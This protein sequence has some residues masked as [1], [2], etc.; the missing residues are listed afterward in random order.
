MTFTEYLTAH[1]EG[2]TM[3]LNH[4]SVVSTLTTTEKWVSSI[5]EKLP[6]LTGTEKQIVWAEKLRSEK[7]VSCVE[8]FINACA[9]TNY[10]KYFE[11]D[12]HIKMNDDSFKKGWI[13]LHKIFQ[14][15]EAKYFIDNREESF[16]NLPEC[17]DFKKIIYSYR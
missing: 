3:I 10:K 5:N 11:K 6:T 9:G 1:Q 7:V 4:H 14:N 12:I 15:T 2:N 13:A 16:I 17:A 8:G